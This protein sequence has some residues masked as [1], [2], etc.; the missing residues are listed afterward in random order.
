MSDIQKIRFTKGIIYLTLSSIFFIASICSIWLIVTHDYS[1]AILLPFC[2]AGFFFFMLSSVDSLVASGSTKRNPKL[3]KFSCDKGNLQYLYGKICLF[4]S[5]LFLAIIVSCFWLIFIMDD[6]LYILIIV[7]L[8]F[9]F[10]FVLTISNS[11]SSFYSAGK[12]LEDL[13]TE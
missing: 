12:Y 13:F 4:T 7:L 2:I 8:S 5:Y 9:A 6:V 10:V 11:V 1:F 3:V